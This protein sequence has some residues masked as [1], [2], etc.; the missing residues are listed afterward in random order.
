MPI[1][2]DIN[3]LSATAASNVDLGGESPNTLDDAFQQIMAFIAQLRDK[4]P[5]S[6]IWTPTA[7]AIGGSINVFQTRYHFLRVANMIHVAGRIGFDPTAATGAITLTPP[8]GV[9]FTDALMCN[10]AVSASLPAVAATMSTG[11]NVSGTDWIVLTLSGMTPG[12]PVSFGFSG[13]Q[14][15]DSLPS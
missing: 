15:V 8:A 2:T 11:Q 1:P 3:A 4:L 13:L 10:G 6:G 14:F 5:T 12:T 9:Y 7:S